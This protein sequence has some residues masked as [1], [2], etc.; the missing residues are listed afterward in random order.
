MALSC[1]T[2]GLDA[3]DSFVLFS[4]DLKKTP[5]L[6][7]TNASTFPSALYGIKNRHLVE[8]LREK[9]EYVQ[10][11]YATKLLFSTTTVQGCTS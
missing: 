10:G 11:V 8:N 6:L 1:Q 4:C 3:V 5:V 2:G 7:L 9:G